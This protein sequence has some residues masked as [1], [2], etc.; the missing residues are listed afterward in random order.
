VRRSIG[1]L[2]ISGLLPTI[3]L[4]GA[5]GVLLLRQQ[6]DAVRTGAETTARFTATLASAKLRDEMAAVDM[7][8]QSPAFDG[9]FDLVRFRLLAS[10]LRTSQS[11]WRTLSV[12]DPA[13]RRLVDVPAPI[14]GSAGGPVVD[15]IS[16]DQ[17]VAA[18]RPVIGN[19]VRGPRGGFAFAIRAPVI[20]NGQVRYVISAIIGA[21]AMSPLLH[22]RALP[23]GW[24]A[25]VLDGNGDMVA[26]SAANSTAIG[27]KASASG[28]ESRRSGRPHFYEFRR[29]DGTEA[30]GT[31]APIEGTSWSANVS[32]PASAFS[33][34]VRHALMLL[35]VVALACLLLVG[36]LVKLLLRELAQYRARQI[37]ETQSQ[38]M[39]ALGRLTGGVAHDF[40]NLLTPILGGLDLIR[41]RVSEDPRSLRYIDTAIASAERARALV[42]RLLS[43]AR[44]QTLSQTDIDPGQM[45]EELRELL[46]QAA[47]TANG[48]EMEISP[49]L[50]MI[51]A[52]RTQLEL[53]ILNLTI[54]ARDAMPDGGTIRVTATAVVIGSRAELPPGHYVAIAVGDQGH[55]M[56]E[57][58]LRRAVD[59]FF[60]T[61]AA[62]KGTGLGLSMVHGFA[63]QSGGMLRIESRP[64]EGTTAAIILPA[65]T[66]PAQAVDR[67]AS[68]P[69]TGT[70]RLL[71]VDDEEAVRVATAAMLTEAGYT[72]L[73]ASSVDQALHILEEEG[74][75]DAVLTDYLMPGRNGADLVREIRRTRPDMPILLI[76]GYADAAQDIPSDVARL[77]K[78]YRSAELIDAVNRLR[79]RA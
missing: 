71:L 42:S 7:V 75:V 13:G 23:P 16:F 55:G 9:P 73:Q 35:G 47:G 28:L 3:A 77:P 54:N 29:H 62:D 58:T 1:L 25:A 40:N 44:R 78:P 24:R 69:T 79:S 34:P 56:D 12:A 10:R 57:E 17:A 65:A 49:H 67:E 14:G 74:E 33:R 37:A 38:R 51:H 59:P 64:G 6:H 48:V 45:L 43:F 76:T 60:T 36:L 15:R 26:S 53:A 32:A 2:I 46:V 5:F 4:G 18:R 27:L 31:W 50:P 19:V 52:D 61:K 11:A 68:G 41:R 22:F 30:I 72:P 66:T 20:R 8:A 70:G 63:A 39:E 21:D